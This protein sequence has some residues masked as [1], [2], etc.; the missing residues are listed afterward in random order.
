MKKQ[1]NRNYKDTVF[2]MLFQKAGNALALY[3]SLNGTDYVDA[4]MLT[5]NTLENAIYMN[6]KNDV[7]F[8]IASRMNLYEH[9]STWNPNMPLRNLLYAAD[10][11]QEFLK[12]QSLYS[13][14]LQ[15]IPV[16]TFV[17]FYNGTEEMDECVELRLSDAYEFPVQDPAL[18][19]KVQ[20]ININPGKNEELKRQCPILREYMI[21]VEKVR[22]YAQYMELT[23][24]VE[25]AIEECIQEG[26][27]KDFLQKQKREVIMVSIYEYD[28]ERELKLIRADERELGIEK[29]IAQGLAE[30]MERGM[31]KTI[32]ILRELNTPEEEI[33]RLVAEKYA[34][35]FIP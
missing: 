10:M 27:L 2:R 22:G 9:Q 8:L 11:L 14:K 30:G 31:Q 5:Y 3:N 28:E 24:A 18:E 25:R 32:E 12:E 23:A 17:V 4:D 13:S 33:E 29:G 20:V 21:Y 1:V 16:P 35:S 7:S 6:M 15:R 26:V 34:A 19:L